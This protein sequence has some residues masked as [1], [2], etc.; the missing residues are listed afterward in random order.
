[1]SEE[2]T[3]SPHRSQ[4][5]RQIFIP[6]WH[7]FEKRLVHSL[8]PILP[9]QKHQLCFVS[10]TFRASREPNDFNGGNILPH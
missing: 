9:G 6:S 2:K 8:I 4:R 3:S 10:S 5:F 1:M 7:N